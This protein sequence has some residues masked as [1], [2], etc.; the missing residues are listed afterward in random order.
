MDDPLQLAF[1]SDNGFEIRCS[2]KTVN[3]DE[4]EEVS[5]RRKQG[6][7][8][9]FLSINTT[10]FGMERINSCDLRLDRFVKQKR[11]HR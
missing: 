11:R 4:R 6:R 7:I 9:H 3:R 5:K 8:A 1:N 10:I 2:L